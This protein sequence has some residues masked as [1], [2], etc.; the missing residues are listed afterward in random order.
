MTHITIC[1]AGF[2]SSELL[3]QFTQHPMGRA[4]HCTCND[5]KSLRRIPVPLNNQL[6]SE[7]TFTLH[8]AL[9]FRVV[10]IAVRCKEGKTQN[11]ASNVGVSLFRF[12]FN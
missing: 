2:V 12:C 4:L 10:G 1:N 11:D 9:P 5:A 8:K 6:K 3:V 7:I